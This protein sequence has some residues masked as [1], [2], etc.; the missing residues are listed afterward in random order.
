MMIAAHRCN[1]ASQGSASQRASRLAFFGVALLLFAISAAITIDVC[2]SMA[3]AMPMPGGLPMSMIWMMMPEESWWDASAKF[4]GMWMAMMVAMMLP[5][6]APVLWRYRQ[7]LAKIEGAKPDAMV[8]LMGAAYFFVWT[9][10]GV[11]VFPIGVALAATAM[12][13][14]A[15]A[16]AMPFAVGAIVAIAGALQLTAWKARRLDCCKET[17]PVGC[18]LPINLRSAWRLGIRIGLRCCACCA[19]LMAILVVVGVMDLRAM[20]AVTAA[21]TVERVVTGRERAAR[22]IGAVVVS[23]GLLLVT[24]AAFSLV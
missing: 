2:H 15:L 20:A 11:V 19:N 6:I 10:L 13:E 12:E 5:S 14:P 23:A 7:T 4:L 16:N 21:I 9:I 17:P 1:Q 18:A 22:A 24:R 8:V 3:D